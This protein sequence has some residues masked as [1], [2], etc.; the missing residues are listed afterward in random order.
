MIAGENLIADGLTAYK[1][2]KGVNASA[3][4]RRETLVI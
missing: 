4:I 3:D 1:A 2:N